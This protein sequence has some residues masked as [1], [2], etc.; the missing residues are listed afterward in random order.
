MKSGTPEM[1]EKIKNGYSFSFESELNAKFDKPTMIITG[2]Y[3]TIVGFVDASKIL[4]YYSKGIYEAVDGA[5]HALPIEQP[6]IFNSLVNEW[7][8][9]IR[10]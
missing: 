5:G 6:D 1:I 7:L 10:V 3:D 9:K 8:D 2:L 4:P